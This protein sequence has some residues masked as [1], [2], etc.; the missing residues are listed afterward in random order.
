MEILDCRKVRDKI[1]TEV[2][3]NLS[4]INKTLGI[5]IISIGDND[6]NSVYL[7]QKRNFFCKLGILFKE[8]ILDSDVDESFVLDIID[9][10]NKD[11]LIDGI[12]VELPI[13]S[14]AIDTK[15]ILNRIDY[16]KDVDGLTDI[17]RNRLKNN[18]DCIISSTVVGIM[19]IF[20]YYNINLDNKKIVIV[21]NGYLVGKPLSDVLLNNNLDVI[22][23]DSKTKNISEVIKNADILVSCVGIKNLIKLDEIKRDI[24]IID[25]GVSIVD[26]Y[27]VGDIM[28]EAI[29][30]IDGFITPIIGGVGVVTT[31][32]LA[33]N[34]IKCY[35]FNNDE[36]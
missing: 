6:V 11:D 36:I 27:V 16:R 5:A 30:N 35:R 21:G 2:I 20:K 17:N 7:R 26:G 1:K 33:C 23:C 13:K 10:L 18:K 32:S 12:M 19:E 25:A 15:R 34:L 14:D 3:Y 31:A 24:I 8:F 22:V 4:D 29:D 28:R 9:D